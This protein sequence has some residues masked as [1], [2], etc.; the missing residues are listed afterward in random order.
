MENEHISPTT[1]SFFFF[2]KYQLR[3]TVWKYPIIQLSKV[4]QNKIAKL[5]KIFFSSPLLMDLQIAIF[6]FLQISKMFQDQFQH[7]VFKIHFIQQ[8]L[9][10]LIVVSKFVPY[11][12]RQSFLHKPK[13]FFC[14]LS[15]KSNLLGFRLIIGH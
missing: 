3:F 4:R 15:A 13:D 2:F 5:E 6:D 1:I 11:L 14:N 8:Y 7:Y 9:L 10:I 12:I